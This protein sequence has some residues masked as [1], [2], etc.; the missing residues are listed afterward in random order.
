MYFLEPANLKREIG[1]RN[2]MG[3]NEAIALFLQSCLFE[4]NLT[5]ITIKNYQD[6][7]KCFLRFFPEKQF[8][9]D[10]LETDIQSFTYKQSIND[11]KSSTI[12]RRITVLKTFYIFLEGEGIVKNLVNEVVIPKGQKT[13]PVYLT[14]DEVSRLLEAPDIKTIAGKRD[15][16][17]IEVMYSSGLRVSE[18][19]NLQFKQVNAQEG[20]VTVIGKGKKERSIPI[21]NTALNCLNDYIIERNKN[22]IVDKSYIFINKNGK[23][24][25]RQYFF[26]QIRKYAKE[27][28]IEKTIHPHTLRHSFATHL[29]SNGANL[30]AVQEMLGHKNIV[31]T[32]IYTHL[33]SDKIISVYDLYWDKK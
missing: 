8:T 20:I 6:D 17:M 19:I 32:Q 25:S 15:K 22:K 28:G 12:T 31:T 5:Q 26:I 9:N 4:R 11:L 24:I 3:I 2:N 21:R 33:E 13:L 14:V 30:R 29:L 23:K 10:L 16:A 7:L 18:L 27:C 1:G